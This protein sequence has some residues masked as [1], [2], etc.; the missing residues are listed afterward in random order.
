MKGMFMN[1]PN[2]LRK[3]WQRTRWVQA[4]AIVL[5]YT[6]PV[7]V[8]LMQEFDLNLGLLKWLDEAEPAV[9]Y[10]FYAFGYTLLVLAVLLLLLRFLCGENPSAL[11]LKTGTWWKDMLGGIALVGLTL[12]VKIILDPIIAK[13]FY[14][15]SD[16]ESGLSDLFSVLAGNLWLLALFLGPVLFIGVA[17][18]E[19][20]TRVFFITRWM[21]IFSSKLWLGIGVFLSAAL[22]GLNHVAQGPAGIISVSLNGLI[23]V[24]WYL[25]FGRIFHLV[26]AHYL[27]D[28]I[29]IVFVVSLIWRGVI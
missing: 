3:P 13:Y 5:G 16:S 23:M 27:Y 6:L 19:E 25:R 10:L 4:L 29:Q 17:G 24:L 9:G 21:K 14:R 12:A 15:A 8:F 22:F 2:D 18:S 1:T 28:A 20:L 11:N 7:L 26:V